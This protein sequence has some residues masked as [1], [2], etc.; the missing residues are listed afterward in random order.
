MNTDEYECREVRPDPKD[1]Y[2]RDQQGKPLKIPAGWSL[3][4]PGDAALSR[5]IKKAHDC[6]I[7]K[8]QKRRR[9]VSLGILSDHATIER[10]RAERA[11][12]LED[13]SYQRKLDAG[14]ARREKQE[15][16]YGEEF[17]TAVLAFLDF[18]PEHLSLAVRMAQLVTDHAIP[19]GSN[20]VGRTKRIPIEQR[21]ESA[22]I[23]WMGHQ[24]TA[25]DEMQIARVK[26]ERREVRRKLAARSRKVLAKYREHLPA[27][28]YTACPLAAV[29]R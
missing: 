19:V 5:R 29:L 22:V 11:L 17:R 18:A 25:Y 23:A 26:G 7:I 9:M 24:N 28:S 2:V 10:L 4:P 20:T 21:A 13:P 27:D 1:G 12:E 16:A 3:L 14:R 15:V 8:T 6:W